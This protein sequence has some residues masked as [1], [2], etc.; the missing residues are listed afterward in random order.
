VNPD[1]V[2]IAAFRDFEVIP[3]D[4]AEPSAANA[5]RLHDRVIFPSAFPRTAQRLM[6][7]GLRVV[8]VDATELAKAEG[9][10]TCC[11]LILDRAGGARLSAGANNG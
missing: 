7:R 1:W 6:Q 2:D 5:L 10:V 8:L 3:I 9:A 4:P 11:S